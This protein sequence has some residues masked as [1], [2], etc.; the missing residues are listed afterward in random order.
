M[1]TS[2]QAGKHYLAWRLLCVPFIYFII[3]STT[4]CEWKLVR[5]TARLERNPLHTSSLIRL[6]DWSKTIGP[7]TQEATLNFGVL[8]KNLTP[9]WFVQKL[10]CRR[11]ATLL[12]TKVGTLDLT[13]RFENDTLNNSNNTLV[14]LFQGDVR[15]TVSL[16]GLSPIIALYSPFF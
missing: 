15:Y 13:F 9:R 12:Y 11:I 8:A 16:L 10:F 3:S 2:K 14:H 7:W 6:F 4:W 1:S 5:P